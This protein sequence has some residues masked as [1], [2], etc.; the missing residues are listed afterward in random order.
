MI[1]NIEWTGNSLKIIDQTEL[2]GR[3]NLIE[4]NDSGQVH[5]AI[6]KLRIRGAPAL[7][8]A[9]AFGLFLGLKNKKTPT[10]EA[11]L[12]EADA[13]ASYLSGARPT[14]VNLH[15][16]LQEIL[17]RLSVSESEPA[18]LLQQ[19]L[20]QA[21]ELQS[22]DKLRCQKISQNGSELIDKGMTILTHCN[23]G[24]LA[25]AGMGTALGVIFAA[26]EQGKMIK[27]LVD[28]T[29]PLLQGARLTMWELDQQKIPATLISDNMAAYAMQR[30]MV[31]MVLLGADRITANGDVAN[32]IGTYNL[33]VLA[34]YHQLPFYVAAPL[35]SFD[36]SLMSGDQIPIEE[37]D[38]QE[39]T[40]IWNRLDISVPQAKSWNPAFDVTPAKLISG[41]ITE[42][43]IIFPPFEKSIKQLNYPKY[44]NQ[45]ELNL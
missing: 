5:E 39:I 43:G 4:L 3:L 26:S 16:A 30:K 17:D 12:T 11:F 41:I 23:T 19:V 10:R 24:A 14:A 28:E 8:V 1:T 25:T 45:E 42:E 29:R 31:D 40:R 20:E 2:P 33:A 27:V 34:Q 32:K 44:H 21:K 37:R 13:I 22:D 7:G 18:D 15:W 35:S 38:P 9:A 6:Q 36:Y